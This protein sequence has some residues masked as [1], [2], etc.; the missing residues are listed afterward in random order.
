MIIHLFQLNCKHACMYLSTL[1][2]SQE[3]TT[4]HPINKQTETTHHHH[5]S[6]EQ[7]YSG[8]SVVINEI[9]FNSETFIRS[10]VHIN[11]MIIHF[12]FI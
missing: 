4:N 2:Q 11:I 1:I 6:S 12:L 9:I 5:S 10:V 8:E 3:V 7:T